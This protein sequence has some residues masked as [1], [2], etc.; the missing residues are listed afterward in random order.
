MV[1]T[2]VI[3]RKVVWKTNNQDQL[4]LLPPSYDDLVP[5]NHPVRIVNTILDQIDLS[6]LEKTYKGGVTSS[7]HPKLLLKILIYAYLRNLYSS[8]KIEEALK[9]NLHFMWLSGNARPDHNTINNFRS[10]KLK[11]QFKKIFN[12][13]VVLLAEQGYLSLKDI[14]VDGTK[15]EANANRYTF[16]WAKS[17]KT[18]RKRIEKQLKELW[19]YVWRRYIKMKSNVLTHLILKL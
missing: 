3:I 10:G 19:S 13:V 8:R 14:Y 17:I 15:I 6:V 9:E 11:G 1:V 18:S 16:V 4:S 12:Q 5:K 7:Y 2:L